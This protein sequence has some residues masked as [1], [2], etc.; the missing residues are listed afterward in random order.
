[1]IITSSNDIFIICWTSRTGNV[2]NT[3]LKH[4]I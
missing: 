2:L 4:H 3:T 1:M